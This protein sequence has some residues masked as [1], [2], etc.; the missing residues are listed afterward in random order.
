MNNGRR[1]LVVICGPTAVGKT[2]VGIL[3]ARRLGGEV[4]SADS[5][6]VYRGMNIGTAKPTVEERQGVPHHL[7]D[8]VDPDTPFSV[9]LYQHLAEKSIAAIHARGRLPLLVGGT[10]LY[11][12][13]VVDPYRFVAGPDPALRRRL[14]EEARLEGPEALHARLAAVD[15]VAAGR[16]HPHNVRRV[17]RALEVYHQT[18]KPISSFQDAGRE[19]ASKYLLW[20]FGLTMPRE[21]L[22]RHIE[23]RVDRMLAAGLVEEVQNLL[24]RGYRRHQVSMQALGYK[25]IAAYLEGELS[26]EEAVRLLKRNT[27]RF[28]KRQFTWF[29][30]DP[31]IRWLDVD[32]LGGPAGAAEEII[33]FLEGLPAGVNWQP[34]KPYNDNFRLEGRR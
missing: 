5:M 7:I 2:E 25:E 20:M 3:V 1:P 13:S 21:K 16:I 8:I 11:I 27:R 10:G 26:L 30:R 34:A 15:P 23:E 33:A 9:A 14:M 19:T 17:I 32:A 22:Y 18:G 31:R 28:A 6:M 4:V 12:R 24:K 29:R